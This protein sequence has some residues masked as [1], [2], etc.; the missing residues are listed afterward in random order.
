MLLKNCLM[1]FGHRCGLQRMV[2]VLGLVPSDSQSIQPLAWLAHTACHGRNPPGDYM[3]SPG[4]Q[5]RT[6]RTNS[7]GFGTPD[8]LLQRFGDT[9]C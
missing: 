4:L 1:R 2:I 3:F 7:P 5:G 9:I 8:A 6:K